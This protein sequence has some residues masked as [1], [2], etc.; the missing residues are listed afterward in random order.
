[1]NSEIE[2]LI[3]MLSGLVLID[4]YIDDNFASDGGSA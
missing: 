2:E 4:P 3:I 1:M